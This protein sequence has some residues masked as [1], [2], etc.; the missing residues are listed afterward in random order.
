LD[1]TINRGSGTQPPPLSAMSRASSPVRY[2]RGFFGGWQPGT[3]RRRGTTAIASPIRVDQG[4]VVA[5]VLPI[6]VDG[7]RFAR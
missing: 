5:R 2:G 4:P 7:R 6:G 3:N 1:L